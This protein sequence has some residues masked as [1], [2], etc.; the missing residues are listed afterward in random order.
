METTLPVVV[1]TSNSWLDGLGGSKEVDLASS[2]GV[3]E[4]QEAFL[5]PLN[6]KGQN[7]MLDSHLLSFV[8]TVYHYMLFLPMLMQSLFLRLLL[9]LF[10]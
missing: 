3:P 5:S 7:S 10:S 9:L 8:T 6:N 2:H 1:P 4:T